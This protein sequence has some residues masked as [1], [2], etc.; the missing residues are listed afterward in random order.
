[1]NWGDL[2][3][4]FV[5]SCLVEGPPRSQGM[6]WAHYLFGSAVLRDPILVLLFLPGESA[7]VWN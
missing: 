1:M 4:G 2:V 5:P 3:S 6:G 7:I